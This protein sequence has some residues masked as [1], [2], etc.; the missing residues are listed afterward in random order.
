M[1]Y[2]YSI[3]L[4]GDWHPVEAGRYSSTSIAGA[5]L[6]IL[7]QLLPIGYDANQFFGLVLYDLRRDWP[8]NAS[9]FEITAVE[10]GM[11]DDH[12]ARR[13]RYRVQASP[14]YCAVD[15]EELL[16]VS[17]VLPGH[18]HGFRA[19]LWACEHDALLHAE[20]LEKILDS[21]QVTTRP[22]MYY[23]Q[24]ISANG[25]TVKAAGEVDSAAVEAGAD[26]VVAMLSGRDDIARCMV[27]ERAEL[28]II[29]RGQPVTSLPEYQY[30]RG[31]RDF[32]GR[33][34]D[35]FA[36]RGLGAVSGQPAS[37]AGEEQ[38]LGRP[39]PQHPIYP[40]RGLVAAHEF[41]HGIQNLCFTVDDHEEWNALY[42]DALAAGLYPGTHLMADVHEFFAVFSTAY[43]EV[44]D[45]LGRGNDRESLESR[46]PD[47]YLA[48][49]DIYGGAVLPE[50]YRTRR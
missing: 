25:V 48:L 42:A 39:G 16:V 3:E 34:R 15:V 29:P 41:A 45:E 38:V 28:A 19:R 37:S 4:P 31:T 6:T 7:S 8:P 20:V 17:R 14:Q 13:I 2:D 1:E 43:F 36:I 33:S 10:D 27:R 5:R 46:F 32:T 35:T 22:A 21:F 12:A 40:F 50:A 47:V 44:T 11:Q 9:L 26:I 24:F 30:L 23:E 49:D 18:P